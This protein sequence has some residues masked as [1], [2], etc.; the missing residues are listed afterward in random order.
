MVITA[1]YNVTEEVSEQASNTQRKR[2]KER[3]QFNEDN[4]TKPY[5]REPQ[6]AGATRFYC[7]TAYHNQLQTDR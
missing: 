3:D 6:Y 7:A 2:E 4:K 1:F 5:T